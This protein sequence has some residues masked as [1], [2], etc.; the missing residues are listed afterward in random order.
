MADNYDGTMQHG[1]RNPL[2]LEQ[3][4]GLK[5][6]GQWSELAGRRCRNSKQA[7]VLL[8]HSVLYPACLLTDLLC[9]V[10]VGE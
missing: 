9:E 4:V 5:K 8:T 6:S 1:R 7:I 10:A 2:T 3:L